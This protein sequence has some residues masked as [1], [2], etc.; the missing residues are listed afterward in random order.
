MLSLFTGRHL[1]GIQFKLLFY[2]QYYK[3][4][5]CR[6]ALAE[7]ELEYNE[8]HKSTAVIARFKISQIPASLKKHLDSR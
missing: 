5:S 6:T 3:H 1:Q 2:L 7:A 4:Y 8:K